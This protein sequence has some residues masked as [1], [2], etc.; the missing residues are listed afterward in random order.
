M[1]GHEPSKTRSPVV[2]MQSP[3]LPIL[4][5]VAAAQSEELLR[6]IQSYHHV[7]NRHCGECTI[8]CAVMPVTELQ[9]PE[10]TACSYCTTTGCTVY[11]S[12]PLTCRGWSCE[13]WTGRLG[14]TEE[15]RPDKL[16]L[17]FSFH[18]RF[19]VAHECQPGS[20]LNPEAIEVLNRLKGQLPIMYVD[21]LGTAF[22]VDQRDARLQIE[23]ALRSRSG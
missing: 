1:P 16:G 17:L 19:I 20:A 22:R 23:Q 10:Y 18:P 11:E 12:R 14:L 4:D 21:A 13:W 9:K 7:S 6:E 15:Q 2:R 8:C 5:A 3:S